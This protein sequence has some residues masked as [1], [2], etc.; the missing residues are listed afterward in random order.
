VTGTVRVTIHVW[1]THQSAVGSAVA[2]GHAIGQAF[3]MPA[4]RLVV[5]SVSEQVYI[6][7]LHGW[8]EPLQEATVAVCQAVDRFIEGMDVRAGTDV[9]SVAALRV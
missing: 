4:Q 7:D 1:M 9:T 6:I 3:H 8:S 2:L 5:P